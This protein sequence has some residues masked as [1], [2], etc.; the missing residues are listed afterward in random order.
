M[1]QSNKTAI[2]WRGKIGTFNKV[3]YVY[4]RINDELL[5]V[6]DLKSYQDALKDPTVIPVQIGSVEINKN[7]EQVFKSLIA[8]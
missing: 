5:Y 6:Y 4:R 7:G 3:K 2:E 8:K 1:V